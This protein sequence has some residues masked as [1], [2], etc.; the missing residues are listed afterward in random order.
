MLSSIECILKQIQGRNVKMAKE[1]VVRGSTDI[2][3]TSISL[4]REIVNKVTL[5]GCGRGMVIYEEKAKRRGKMEDFIFRGRHGLGYGEVKSISRSE[6]IEDIL[7]A[8]IESSVAIYKINE[9]DYSAKDLIEKAKY[10]IAQDIIREAVSINKLNYDEL[11]QICDN[12]LD[13]LK[14][15]SRDGELE[16]YLEKEDIQDILIIGEVGSYLD[17]GGWDMLTSEATESLLNNRDIEAEI[18]AF[19]AL[20]GYLNIEKE[21]KVLVI[22]YISNLDADEAQDTI[23]RKLG[24]SINRS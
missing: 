5:V 17:N 14:E 20:D 24:S 16:D 12:K 10:Y 8:G 3:K 4:S 6:L 11:I 2:V 21:L 22:D 13:I 19:I 9:Q 23:E 1:I 15:L 18:D 7:E